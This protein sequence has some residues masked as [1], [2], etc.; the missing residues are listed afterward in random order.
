MGNW[1]YP[2]GA[3]VSYAYGE[4]NEIYDR[5]YHTGVDFGASYGDRVGAASG[6]KVIYVG[7]SGPYGNQII[8][9]H[10]NGVYTQ[11]A[12]L[13]VVG[14]RV[15]D[16]VKAGTAIGKVGTSGT[17][18]SAPHLHFEVRKGGWNF[19]DNADVNPIRFLEARGADN[20]NVR[21][22]VVSAGGRGG[23]G[24]KDKGPHKSDFGFD[25]E[26]LNKHPEIKKLVEDAVKNE[27]SPSQFQARLKETKWWEDHTKA[28][29]SWQV[30]LTED[31]AEAEKALKDSRRSIK[32][33]A[34]QMGVSLSDKQIDEMAERAARNGWDTTDLQ[35]HIGAKFKVGKGPEKGQGAVTVGQLEAMASDYGLPMSNQRLSKWTRNILQGEQTVEGYQNVLQEQARN[36]YPHLSHVIDNNQTIRDWADPFLS[37]ASQ[38]LGVSEAQM[39]LDKGKWSAVLD[40]TKDGKPMT[41]D[42]WQRLL[43]TDDRYGYDK[44]N[45]A[46]ASSAQLTTALAQ[47]FGVI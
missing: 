8:I 32:T 43:R 36:L 13:S 27:W 6:G 37:A 35:L 20:A 11:Y 42:A 44:T 24:G 16:H 39:R 14:V 25:K 9:S 28:Q 7:H 40:E 45:N 33:M 41:M 26:F 10:G 47:K 3:G 2:V 5:G 30:L 18:S 4:H 46:Q 12:H 17:N 22:Q 21:G 15:G 19:N 29:R 38:M 34:S 1:V 31:P 23:G